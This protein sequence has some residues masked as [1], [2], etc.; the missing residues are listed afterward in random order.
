[1]ERAE[2]QRAGGAQY[3]REEPVPRNAATAVRGWCADGAGHRL[4][5]EYVTVG[6][7]CLESHSHFL[8]RHGALP[9]NH[10]QKHSL[11]LE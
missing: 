1:M 9:H 6:N 2:R 4:L 8:M 3:A 10:L 11:C 7:V 5:L